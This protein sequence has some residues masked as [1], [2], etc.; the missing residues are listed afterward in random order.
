MS[1]EKFLVVRPDGQAEKSKSF[2][3]IDSRASSFLAPVPS[4]TESTTFDILS[5]SVYID[6]AVVNFNGLTVDLSTGANYEVSAIPS[7]YYNVAIFT[8]SSSGL[9]EKVEGTSASTKE[10]VIEPSLP[11]GNF[12]IAKVIFQDNGIGG[13]GTVNNVLEE[14]ITDIRPFFYGNYG[15]PI[16]GTDAVADFK[17]LPTIPESASLRI[18]RGTVWMNDGNLVSIP[19]TTISFSSGDLISPSIPANWYNKAIVALDSFGNIKAFWG[20][21]ALDLE[22]VGLAQTPKEAMPIAIV[23]V[24][25]DG[26]ANAGTL[27][28]ILVSDILDVRPLFNNFLGQLRAEDINYCRVRAFYPANKQIQIFDGIVYPKAGLLVN[29]P[30]TTIDFSTG[31]NAVPATTP[32]YYRKILI[33]LNAAGS[34]LIFYGNPSV[35]ISGLVAPPTPRNVIALAYITVQDDGS[36]L[37]GSIL[38]INEEDI[39]DVRP[40]LGA[41]GGGGGEGTTASQSYSDYLNTSTFE[42]GFYEDFSDDDYIDL[43]NTT[44]DADVIVDNNTT[45]QVG[46]ILQTKNLFDDT[47]SLTNIPR[48]LILLSANFSEFLQ[49]EVTNNGTDWFQITTN[50]VKVFTTVGTDLRVRFTNT[51]TGEVILTDWAIFYNDD[52]I[53]PSFLFSNER[54]P[55]NQTINF[56]DSEISGNVITLQNERYYPVGENALLVFKNGELLRRDAELLIP[57]SYKELNASQIEVNVA[58]QSGDYYQLAIPAGFF[59]KSVTEFTSSLNLLLPAKYIVDELVRAVEGTTV[60]VKTAIESGGRVLLETQNWNIDSSIEVT[61]NCYIYS[62]TIGETAINSSFSEAIFEITSAND[63]TLENI[64]LSSLAL[65]P[66]G[67]GVT[68]SSSNS[69]AYFFNCMFENLEKAVEVIGDT[70]NLVFKNCK[71]KDCEIPV[72]AKDNATFEN[73]VF[74]N[75]SVSGVS[76]ESNSFVINCKFINCSTHGLIVNGLHNVIK[77]NNFDSCDNGIIIEATGGESVV[78]GNKILNSTSHGC[79]VNGERVVLNNNICKGNDTGINIE[80]SENMIEGNIVTDNLTDGIVIGLSAINNEIGSNVLLRNP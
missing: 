18:T 39:Q 67:I 53:S 10:G 76:V 26:N 46:E 72:I 45:F 65:S 52:E 62:K 7:N 59:G 35:N 47:F 33:T 25:D 74:E 43:D 56:G 57:N 12:P 36:G 13:T 14:D 61:D 16:F 49:I 20:T 11:S 31:V 41:S 48:V 51:G 2:D 4:E 1:L 54:V 22:D 15:K 58:P 17:A 55:L 23:S 40:F 37:T 34:P 24:R 30:Y 77:G 73:C 28:N 71:F 6:N 60:S 69:S 44:A 5:G 68:I 75:C 79:I 42:Q 38:S 80:G 3:K 9:I 70:E 27:R 63:F 19:D 29:F 21:P 64:K 66:S 32:G 8:L 78:S 50:S